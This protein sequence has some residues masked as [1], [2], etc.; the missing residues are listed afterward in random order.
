VRSSSRPWLGPRCRA[1]V[2][3][4]RGDGKGETEADK[5]EKCNPPKCPNFA[6]GTANFKGRR[7]AA[8]EVD[9]KWSEGGSA[10]LGDP[11]AERGGSGRSF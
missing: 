8:A 10:G 7:L 3:R 1:P 11:G 9:A 5:G 6:V 4:T 2:S